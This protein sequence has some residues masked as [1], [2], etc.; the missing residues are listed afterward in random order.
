MR[1]ELIDSFCE[2]VKAITTDD[3]V[4][5]LHDTD[6]DGITSGVLVGKGILKLRGKPIDL[7]VNQ[8][9]GEKQVTS[10][11]AK[12]LSDKKVTVL[13]T[14]DMAVDQY[15]EVLLGLS[16]QMKIIIIDH[17]KIYN[18]VNSNEILMIKADYV[19][20]TIVPV[21][22]PTAK[23]T[24]DLFSKVIDMSDV[25]WIAAIGTITDMAYGQW[26]DFL[27]AVFLKYGVEKEQNWFD[28]KLGQAGS[29]MS[30]VECY[31]V[32][33][34]KDCFEILY[35]AES[36]Q[37][38]LDSRLK[39]WASVIVKELKIWKKKFQEYIDEH[40]EELVVFEIKC[41]YNIKS[42][43]ISEF[44]ALY[45]HRTL[46]I[47]QIMNGKV[48]ISSRRGD[49]KKECNTLLENAVKGLSDARAG[50]HPVAAG[51]TVL[52]KDLEVFLERVKGV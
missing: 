49:M 20:P 42:N 52:E 40:D 48:L 19:D 14:T 17:H 15:P 26:G 7:R 8:F 13:F 41:K 25:D 29:M 34:V 38:V 10:D 21:R 28:T 39:E 51:A 11:T 6:P 12:L 35:S 50:G 18:D 30:Q 45:P 5:V 3:V 4:A 9:H 44:G 22:Y 24:Y 32:A 37:D 16:K 33:K 31:D 1:K 36:Y 23:L 27:D 46:L 2:R 43:L 47:Y